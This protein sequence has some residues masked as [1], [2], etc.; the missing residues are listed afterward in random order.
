M[1]ILANNLKGKLKG[2]QIDKILTRIFVSILLLVVYLNVAL[3]DIAVLGAR[4]ELRLVIAAIFLAVL[5]VRMIQNW[6]QANYILKSISEN[7][8]LSKKILNYMGL[9]VFLTILAV[10]RVFTAYWI[11]L[12]I[13][14]VL[15]LIEIKAQYKHRGDIHNESNQ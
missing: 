4:D 7:K 9:W 11:I 5:I 10:Y 2:I 8:V 13:W 14:V 6:Q 1:K 3:L 12:G 15:L